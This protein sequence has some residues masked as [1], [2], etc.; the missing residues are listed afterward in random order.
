[1]TSK[2]TMTL[3]MPRRPHLACLH[4]ESATIA[5]NHALTFRFGPMPVTDLVSAIYH[6][7]RI[8]PLDDDARDCV[9]DLLSEPATDDRDQQI[10][11]IYRYTT[12]ERAIRTIILVGPCDIA[13]YI[14]ALW[15]SDPYA[16][17][18]LT[19]RNFR[20]LAKSKLPGW[21]VRKEKFGKKNT[22]GNKNFLD[23]DG[24][25]RCYVPPLQAAA[26]LSELTRTGNNI[27][28]HAWH[29]LSKS[30]QWLTRNAMH[31]EIAVGTDLCQNSREIIMAAAMGIE[32]LLP[33]KTDLATGKVQQ[34]AKAAVRKQMRRFENLAQ[35]SI[36]HNEFIKANGR[37]VADFPI[38]DAKPALK[39]HLPQT[40]AVLAFGLTLREHV[41]WALAWL[42]DDARLESKK[43]AHL[44]CYPK[45]DRM[46]EGMTH[47]QAMWFLATQWL[48]HVG[49][50]VAVLFAQP[51]RDVPQTKSADVH[52]V[53]E[54]RRDDPIDENECNTRGKTMLENGRL[55]RT[56]DV[57][58]GAPC[59]DSRYDFRLWLQP[60]STLHRTL[61]GCAKPYLPL[62]FGKGV[63]DH[64]GRLAPN[65]TVNCNGN[66]ARQQNNRNSK[67]RQGA[68]DICY[69]VAHD[70]M[71]IPCGPSLS[72]MHVMLRSYSQRLHF[73]EFQDFLAKTPGNF[74][75]ANR[76]FENACSSHALFP[77]SFGLAPIFTRSTAI[78]ARLKASAS[79]DGIAAAMASSGGVYELSIL[80]AETSNTTFEAASFR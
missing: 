33:K 20:P 42:Y 38:F 62:G 34:A 49:D 48:A 64:L 18:Q 54:I 39:K 29:A 66:R 52:S 67:A 73:A 65:F 71:L 23:S 58:G 57:T 55:I 27:I 74:D 15:A 16:A 44:L 7:L 35:G 6:A 40:D 5:K 69:G 19:A 32:A 14:V 46:I 8:D 63:V 61:K 45:Q 68:I 4:P 25:P 53:D 2:G 17:Q 9:E 76:L 22:R 31:T 12:A 50:D 51:A 78:F 70:L 28:A 37:Y 56:S 47:G 3:G 30:R 10:L 77:T 1:M 80:S 75:P 13:E 43:S 60:Q 72:S 26:L 11:D 21:A 79:Q 24:L 59:A 41:N 36:S